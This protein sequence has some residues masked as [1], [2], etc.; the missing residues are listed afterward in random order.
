MAYSTTL[1]LYSGIQMFSS[2]VL[3][4]RRVSLNT[5][6][7]HHLKTAQELKRNYLKSCF[8]AK[9]PG[10]S[11]SQKAGETNSGSTKGKKKKLILHCRRRML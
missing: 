6:F 2:A 5:Q 4:P 8:T 3:K 1:I 11:T 9:E 7:T 10:Y